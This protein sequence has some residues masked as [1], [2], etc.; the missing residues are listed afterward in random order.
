[1]AN[2]DDLMK[3]LCDELEDIQKGYEEPRRVR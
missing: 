1:M 2:Y 3:M